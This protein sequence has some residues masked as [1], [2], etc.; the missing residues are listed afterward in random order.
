MLAWAALPWAG[1]ADVPAILYELLAGQ[2]SGNS[3]AATLFGSNNPSGKLP[4]TFPNPAPAGQ[5]WPTDTWLSPPGGGPVMPTSWPGTDRGRGFPEADYAEELL[6]SVQ[7]QHARAQRT[8]ESWRTLTH[9]P[10]P[11]PPFFTV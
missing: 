9:T 3:I 5:T 7:G 2:E 4:L 11:S 1:S 6:M 8:T 10:T